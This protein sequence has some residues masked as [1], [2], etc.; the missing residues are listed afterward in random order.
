M[1]S[2]DHEETQLLTSS[3]TLSVV[4]LEE[5]NYAQ[6]VGHQYNLILAKLCNY[7]HPITNVQLHVAML[8]VVASCCISRSTTTTTS[9]L[10]CMVTSIVCSYFRNFC[11]L[12]QNC[13]SFFVSLLYL[14]LNY[15]WHSFI[16]PISLVLV[17]YIGVTQCLK[18]LCVTTFW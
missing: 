14:N 17:V 12:F 2:N 18:A 5:L 10:P 15:S 11:P 6:M 8:Y 9:P 1:A 7:F 16:K 13:A 4:W 3:G